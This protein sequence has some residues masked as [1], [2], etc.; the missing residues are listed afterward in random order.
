MY[1]ESVADLSAEERRRFFARRAP[2][3]VRARVTWSTWLH[4]LCA[5]ATTTRRFSLLQ[6]R[7]G[8]IRSTTA[9]KHRRP[10]PNPMVNGEPRRDRIDSSR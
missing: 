9:A 7:C 2:W 4:G 6:S 8:S 1:L 3:R 10:A 5:T